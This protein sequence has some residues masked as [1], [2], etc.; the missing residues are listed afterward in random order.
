[1]GKLHPSIFLDDLISN[2]Y[3]LSDGSSLR[4]YDLP[5]Q[6]YVTYDLFFLK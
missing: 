3:T 6:A 4:G 2:G 1:M 5:S